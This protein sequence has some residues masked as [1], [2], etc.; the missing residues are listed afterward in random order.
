MDV[1]IAHIHPIDQHLA[2]CAL[3]QAGE[4]RNLYLFD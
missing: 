2:G 4:Q 3:V 1:E